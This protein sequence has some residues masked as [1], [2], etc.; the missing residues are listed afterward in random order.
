MPELLSIH[1]RCPRCSQLL[2]VPAG[3]LQSVFRCARCQYRVIG[4]ALMEEARLSPPRLGAEPRESVAGPFV[5][6][7]DDQHTRLHLPA[8]DCE[9]EETALPAQLVGDARSSVP[10]RASLPPQLTL[11][12]FDAGRDD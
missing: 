11:S 9:E 6:D 5:E 2:T 3:Q 12:R 1:G 8:T 4:S 7:P 10:P